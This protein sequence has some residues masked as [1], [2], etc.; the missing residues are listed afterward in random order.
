M[1]GVR[2]TLIRQRVTDGN[3][4]RYGNYW[5]QMTCFLCSDV[6][7]LVGFVAII[8]LFYPGVVVKCYCRFY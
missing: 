4:Y 2:L 1:G 8:T 7:V 5:Q 3:G 6:V